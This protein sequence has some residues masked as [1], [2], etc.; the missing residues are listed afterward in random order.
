MVV[1]C[2][3]CG[4]GACDGGILSGACCVGLLIVVV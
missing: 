2:Y 3:S 1:A 4:D